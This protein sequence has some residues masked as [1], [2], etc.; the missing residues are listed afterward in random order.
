MKAIYTYSTFG[1]KKL[2]A[3]EKDVPFFLKMAAVSVHSA[4][5]N[6]DD[7]VC[8]TDDVNFVKSLCLPFTAIIEVPYC[9]LFPIS[10][11]WWNIHKLVTYSMQNS[12]FLHLDFDVYLH[13]DFRTNNVLNGDIITEQLRSYSAIKPMFDHAPE[14]YTK[15]LVKKFPHGLICSGL[16][17]SSNPSV[18]F[19]NLLSYALQ[20]IKRHTKEPKFHDLYS[21][22]EFNLSIIALYKDLEVEPLVR[23]TFKHWQ[24]AQKSIIYKQEVEAAYELIGFK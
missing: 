11:K 22:E 17:G 7:V 20:A 16:L 5:K 8:Y 18:T 14:W 21:I 6:F 4:R 2:Y 1:G 23:G 3:N 19:K 10:E 12:P 24:G 15:E 9:E 13:D